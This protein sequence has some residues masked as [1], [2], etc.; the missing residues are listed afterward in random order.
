[1]DGKSAKKRKKA[2][3]RRYGP[4]KTRDFKPMDTFEVRPAHCCHRSHQHNHH[5]KRFH[6][7]KKG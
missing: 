7:S 4:R 2:T 1:M 5:N 3:R 6:I